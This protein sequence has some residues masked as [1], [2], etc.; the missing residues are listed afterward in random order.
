MFNA[1][2]S[3]DFSSVW[4]DLGFRGNLYEIDPAPPTEEGE[5]LLVGRAGELE[6]LRMYLTS[7]STHPTIEGQNG[8]GHSSLVAV[9]LKS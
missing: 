8:V 6:D 4:T 1:V 9:T 7:S 2:T 5:R 3:V